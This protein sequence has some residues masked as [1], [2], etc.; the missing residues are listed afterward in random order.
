M[1]SKSYDVP[2]KLACT[3][4]VVT[5]FLGRIEATGITSGPIRRDLTNGL[6]Q[7][8]RR[9]GRLSNGR[10]RMVV[11][12]DSASEQPLPKHRLCLSRINKSYGMR[13]FRNALGVDMNLRGQS[14]DG[15]YAMDG[16]LGLIPGK[17]FAAGFIGPWFLRDC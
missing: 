13:F 16:G 4:V 2:C 11:G 3:L 8:Q 17:R 1:P 12:S 6:Q 15:P 7:V 10:N 5:I 9:A 14:A